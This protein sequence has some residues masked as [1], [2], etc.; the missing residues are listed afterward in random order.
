MTQGSR[1]PA[2]VSTVAACLDCKVH[3]QKTARHFFYTGVVVVVASPDA[4]W[5]QVPVPSTFVYCSGIERTRRDAEKQTGMV[6]YRAGAS[7]VAATTTT[8]RSFRDTGW[9]CRRALRSGRARQVGE[10]RRCIGARP[11]RRII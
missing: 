9:P 2:C 6:Q 5:A 3:P 7:P 1:P 11:V 4:M 8:G 10:T